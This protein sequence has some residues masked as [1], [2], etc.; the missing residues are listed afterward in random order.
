MQEQVN[1]VIDTVHSHNITP[2]SYNYH[3]IHRSARGFTQGENHVIVYSEYY[4]LSIIT[5]SAI[6]ESTVPEVDV[7]ETC[8]CTGK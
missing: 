5:I 7:H 3:D 4:Y 6:I 2:R 1:R 8:T